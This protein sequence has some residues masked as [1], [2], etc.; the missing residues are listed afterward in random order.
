MVKQRDNYTELERVLTEAKLRASVG[1]GAI[2]HGSDVPF[3]RQEMCLELKTF[4]ITPAVVQIRKK[5]KECLR[6][7]G[8]H[9]I[10]ELL[11]VIV[12]A[13]SAVIVLQEE[14]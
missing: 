11:D 13:A 12:Y 3:E 1:K 10:N 14:E 8:E 2:R 4:G 6:L 7:R 5:A 9:Q